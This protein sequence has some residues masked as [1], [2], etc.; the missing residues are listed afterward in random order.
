MTTSVLAGNWRVSWRSE[1]IATD[2]EQA[3][4]KNPGLEGS[5]FESQ[6]LQ[7]DLDLWKFLFKLLPDEKTERKR[8]NKKSRSGPDSRL[9]RRLRTR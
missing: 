1:D 9:T 7:G 3:Q 5:R 8:T 6:N 4:V 2:R